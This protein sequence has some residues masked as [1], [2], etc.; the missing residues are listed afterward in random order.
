M[1]GKINIKKKKFQF[2]SPKPFNWISLCH[3]WST[4]NLSTDDLVHTSECNYHNWNNL[5]GENALYKCDGKKERMSWFFRKYSPMCLGWN[6]N[7]K[8]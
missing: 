7:V 4:N 2:S 1:A 3:L 6:Q 5:M 8:K